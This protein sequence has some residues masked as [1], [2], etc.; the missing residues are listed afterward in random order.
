MFSIFIEVRDAHDRFFSPLFAPSCGGYK[1]WKRRE[2]ETGIHE[3]RAG[4]TFPR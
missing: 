3:K 2:A 1:T 4:R